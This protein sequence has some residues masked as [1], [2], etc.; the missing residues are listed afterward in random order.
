MD[1]QRGFREVIEDKA[2]KKRAYAREYARKRRAEDPAFLE[3]CRAAGRK[4]RLKRIDKARQE[5]IE[6]RENNPEKTKAYRNKYNKENRQYLTQLSCK[7]N[8][9]RRKTD[10]TF[11]LM[12]RERVRVYDALKGIRK[13][14][15][16]ETL[17][18]CSYEFFRHYIEGL[19]TDG[20]GWHNMG[21]W[22]IDHIK[23][24]A[25]FDLTN[26]KEQYIAF[27]YKNQQPLWAKDNLAK[28]AKYIEV[29]HG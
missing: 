25:S 15:R 26:E 16:T 4:A 22:H 9:E 18:G 7:R 8:K 5:T 19:F 1:T 3:S 27:N 28:G 11:A 23:P 10:P 12:R 13:S 24:L 2:E 6:W 29:A 14:A 20:M 21:E 17:L